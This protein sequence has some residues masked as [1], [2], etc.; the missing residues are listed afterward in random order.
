VW[1]VSGSSSRKAEVTGSR[2]LTLLNLVV[3]Q[4]SFEPTRMILGEENATRIGDRDATSELKSLNPTPR[5]LAEREDVELI[6]A[7]QISFGSC[8]SYCKIG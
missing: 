6:A 5:Q 3:R 7:E 8:V 1:L 2:R 4:P